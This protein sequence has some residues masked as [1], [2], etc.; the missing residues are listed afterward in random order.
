[1]EHPLPVSRETF[2]HKCVNSLIEH[3]LTTHCGI[4]DFIIK[5]AIHYDVFT[6]KK[7]VESKF[8]INF[9]LPQ[10]L[11]FRNEGLRSQDKKYYRKK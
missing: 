7:M 9:I 10:D 3:V 8:S 5:Y 4:V 6:S 11:N 2:T 1:M